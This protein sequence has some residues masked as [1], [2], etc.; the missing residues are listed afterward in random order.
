MQDQVIFFNMNHAAMKFNF[1]S[2]EGFTFCFANEEDSGRECDQWITLCT[3]KL[4]EVFTSARMTFKWQSSKEGECLTDSPFK[5]WLALR[6]M[7]LR[8]I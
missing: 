6:P 4:K 8:P 2:D 1:E 3:T 7:A 5:E